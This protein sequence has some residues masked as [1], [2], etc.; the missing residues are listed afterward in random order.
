MFFAIHMLRVDVNDVYV[1]FVLLVSNLPI[2]FYV[3]LGCS[4]NALNDE[5]KNIFLTT[6]NYITQY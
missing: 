3:L 4:C 1:Y 5:W 2:W 6:Y